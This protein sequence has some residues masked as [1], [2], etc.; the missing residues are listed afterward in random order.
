MAQLALAEGG[1][2]EI[3]GKRSTPERAVYPY[4]EDEGLE[5]IRIDGLQRANDGADTGE[6]VEIRKLESKPA[7]PL[8]FPP[9]PQNPRLLRYSQP[10]IHVFVRRPLCHGGVVAPAGPLHFT[11]TP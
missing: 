2:I 8:V 6:Y 10:F 11:T 3:V 9:A 7:T 5:I 4:P 1:V